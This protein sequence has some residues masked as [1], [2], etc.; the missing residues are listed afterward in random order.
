MKM[1]REHFKLDNDLVE[2]FVVKQIL[3]KYGF[4]AQLSEPDETNVITVHIT[5]KSDKQDLATLCACIGKTLE[6][7]KN[8]HA[9]VAEHYLN[10]EYGDE[11]LTL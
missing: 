1:Q 10:H 3:A 11:D 9:I 5:G 7:V 4:T 2:I 8:L 6:L